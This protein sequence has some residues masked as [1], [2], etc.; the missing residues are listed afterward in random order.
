[1][2][3][4]LSNEENLKHGAKAVVPSALPFSRQPSE[5]NPTD[6]TENLENSASSSGLFKYEFPIIKL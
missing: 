5:E 1:V 4:F 6:L 3:L 2:E